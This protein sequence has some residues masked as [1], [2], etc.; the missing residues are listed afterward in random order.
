[1]SIQRFRP[2]IWSAVLLQATETALVFGSPLVVNRD[3]EGDISQ[4]GDTVHIT[5]VGD[6][7]VSDYSS[8]DTL[9]Y[10]DLQD[11]GQTMPIDQQQKF[12]FK[13]D[14]IDK[15]QAKGDVMGVSMK[16]AAYRMAK[17][18]DSYI[19]GLYT[20]VV[21]A[22]AI[23]TTSITT[24]TLAYDNIINLGVKLDEADVP[25]DGRYCV[26]PA[27]YY[28]LLLKSDLFV[29]VDASGGSQGLR[30]GLVGMVDNM[31]II[32][33]NQC[34]NVTGDDY[35]VQAG[36]NSAISFAQ[37]ILQTEALRLQST[38]ADAVRGLDVYGAKLIRP[39]HIATLTASKT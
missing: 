8:G 33:S 24:G 14:D 30:N 20:G 31:P 21:S 16:R 7:T 9:T 11:A 26:V 39:D 25:E 34:I 36:H 23:G 38:F 15:R 28:G 37:Q 1:M 18:K 22:N 4:A 35:I 32:K 27:W 6:P 3:Y 2:E 5:N 10:E 29:R 12:A 17:R 19:A 13:V